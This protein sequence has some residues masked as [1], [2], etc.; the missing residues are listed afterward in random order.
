MQV[1][2]LMHGLSQWVSRRRSLILALALWYVGM[3]L[4]AVPNLPLPP[5]LPSQL[6][7]YLVL[8]FGYSMLLQFFWKPHERVGN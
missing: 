5:F 1:S 2:T 4:F 6:A 7:V 3:I 8:A